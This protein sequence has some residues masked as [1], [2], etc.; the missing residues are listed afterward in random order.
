[1]AN[2]GQSP[3][4]YSSNFTPDGASSSAG[5]APQQQYAPSGSTSGFRLS[6]IAEGIVE[7]GARALQ[8]IAG[9][10]FNFNF[11][12]ANGEVKDTVNDWRIRIS[13][14]PATADL[15][16]NNP[17]AGVLA[18]LSSTAGVIFPY[19]PTV[20]VTHRATYG[21]QALTH[22]NYNAYF[23]QGSAVDRINIT[24]EFT[25]QNIEEGAY[26]MAC[27]AFFRACT[28][29]F[30]GNSQLAGTPPPMV[31]LDGYGAHQL[32]HV[33]CVITE[34]NQQF[35]GDVDYIKVPIGLNNL[36]TTAGNQVQ[37]NNFGVPNR[38]PTQSTLRVTLQPVYSRNNIAD[39]F[40]LER[41]AVGG[42]IQGGNGTRGG[43]L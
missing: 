5:I 4:N 15:F 16:Y 2:L 13:M 32:P 1:M 42:L 26:Y 14:Q 21:E 18:P 43:F 41:Y 30:Y 17:N 12:D 33:P 22:N 24:G 38:I 7:G 11:I 36:R 27:V 35:P 40:T 10:V 19:T 25:V 29:M 39:N 37:T 9:G 28:K 6:T 31:F 3:S 8:S 34:F 23:Y 20:D